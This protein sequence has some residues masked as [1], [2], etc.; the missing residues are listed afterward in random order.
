MFFDLGSECW[1]EIDLIE[2]GKRFSRLSEGCELPLIFFFYT[3]SCYPLAARQALWSCYCR[4][5]L[6]WKFS[7][8]VSEAFVVSGLCIK[9]TQRSQSHGTF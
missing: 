4:W 6:S 1:V 8:C 3:P 5:D 7:E 9:Y 2:K